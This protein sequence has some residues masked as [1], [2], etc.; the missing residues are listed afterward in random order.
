MD[1]RARKITP[2]ATRD[3]DNN[4]YDWNTLVDWHRL[5]TPWLPNDCIEKLKL[6]YLNDAR[7]Q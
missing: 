1:P 5:H 3:W 2:Q 6:D 7:K 4:V